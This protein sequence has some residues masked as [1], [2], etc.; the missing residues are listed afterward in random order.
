M[1][2]IIDGIRKWLKT[3]DGFSDERIN[4]GFLP[5]EVKTYSVDSVPTKEVIK[6][7]LD[8]SSLRQFLFCVSSREFYGEDIKQNVDTHDFYEELAAWLEKQCKK[9]SFPDIGEGRI[10]RSIEINSNAYPFV[11]DEHG[12]ARYQIQINMIYYQKGTRL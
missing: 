8:G 12:T 11:A 9:R 3:Y 7:Y 4:V 2:T 10:V 5:D 6:K 1:S